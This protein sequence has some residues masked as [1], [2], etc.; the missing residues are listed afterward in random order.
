[1]LYITASVSPSTWGL[2]CGN[3][4]LQPGYDGVAVSERKPLAIRHLLPVYCV[5]ST[6]YRL[7]HDALPQGRLAQQEAL[8]LRLPML[9]SHE[10]HLSAFLR[11]DGGN[12]LFILHPVWYLPFGKSRKPDLTDQS[13]NNPG[14]RAS[15]RRALFGDAD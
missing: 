12:L 2:N 14:K 7:Y 15:C 6:R 8:P 4:H 13:Q 10:L 3:L 5:L 1:M 11:V 9:S